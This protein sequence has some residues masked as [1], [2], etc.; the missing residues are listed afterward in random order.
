MLL[1][2]YVLIERTFPHDRKRILVALLNAPVTR[3][4]SCGELKNRNV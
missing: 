3:K 1:L 2:N 4:W